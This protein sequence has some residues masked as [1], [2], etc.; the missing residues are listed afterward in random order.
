MEQKGN[1]S[2]T[3]IFCLV[4]TAAFVVL[5]G[6]LFL[7]QRFGDAQR[8]YAVTTWEKTDA[9]QTLPQKIDINA[10][11]TEELQRLP[12]IGPVLARRIVAFLEEKGYTFGYASYWNANIMTELSDGAVEVA[13][14]A[15]FEEMSFFRWSSPMKYYETDYHQGKTFLLLAEDQR[16]KYGELFLMPGGNV[17]YED[18][19]YMVI[20][21]DSVKEVL[22]GQNK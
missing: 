3:E 7:Q 10:A 21:F 20:H 18:E 17:V 15:D 22:K 19:T 5:C 13:N 1:F 9:A 12:G 2:K 8:G 6:T 16:E 4:L 11:D 14:I